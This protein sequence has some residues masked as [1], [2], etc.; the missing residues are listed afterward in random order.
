M[1]LN[2]HFIEF[3]SGV[4]YCSST[5][6]FHWT[7]YDLRCNCVRKFVGTALL[8][9]ATSLCCDH[10]TYF[11]GRDSSVG[12]A[13]R[14][15]LDGPG[16]ESWCGG[17]IFRTRPDRPCGPPSLLYNGYRVFPGC[18][19][20]GASCWPPTPSKYRGHERV[21]LYLYSP[22]G[23]SWSA[24][25]RTNQLTKIFRNVGKVTAS[26]PWRHDSPCS[27]LLSV[28]NFGSCQSSKPK[29]YEVCGSYLVQQMSVV[30]D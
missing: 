18:K 4:W 11:V 19:A 22:S 12:I 21:G 13:T 14:Y 15:G 7:K 20:A 30:W 25:G 16:I 1:S 10:W 17:E 5:E 8:E 2:A 3:Q 6:M 27:H 29:R 26:Y 24:I 9:G 23:P 28:Y